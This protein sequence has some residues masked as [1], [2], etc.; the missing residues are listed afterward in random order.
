M[1]PAK[2]KHAK[3]VLL[4]AADFLD[5]LTKAIRERGG[6]SSSGGESRPD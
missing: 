5:A 3:K 6:R 2:R 4:D 1:T